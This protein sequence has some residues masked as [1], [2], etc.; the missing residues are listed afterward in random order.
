MIKTI[1]GTTTRQFVETGKSK[2]SGLDTRLAVRRLATLER[3]TSLAD[4]DGL[5]SVGLHKLK[6]DRKEF[7]SV[8]IN[9]PWRLVFRFSDG[10]AYDVEI[11][12]YH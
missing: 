4:F 3:A 11:V 2:F 10:D 5:N 6:G 9:G 12:D 7:W 8:K 1:R